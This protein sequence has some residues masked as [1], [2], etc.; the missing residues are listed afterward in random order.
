MPTLTLTVSRIDP[1]RANGGKNNKI[2][3]SV[4][5][6]IYAPP[7][8]AAQFKIGRSYE[9]D[10]STSEYNNK[11]YNNLESFTEVEAKT[12]AATLPS[13]G[14][15]TPF[16]TPEQSFLSEMLVAMVACGEVKN[17]KI[18]LWNTTKML[19]GLWRHGICGTE[20]GTFEASE[21][22]RRAA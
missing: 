4:G 15:G 7:A 5:E 14:G 11:T 22:G 3:G 19:K 21:A 16:R 13:Q 9:I 6:T 12:P 10:Y 18:Q 17:D 8:K 20:A 1:P 2:I